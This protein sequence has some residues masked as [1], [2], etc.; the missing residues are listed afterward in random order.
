LPYLERA[1]FS[2][3]AECTSLIKQ[4]KD[5]LTHHRSIFSP[6]NLRKLDFFYINT[7]KCALRWNK[8]E[9]IYYWSTSIIN[10]IHKTETRENSSITRL[11]YQTVISQ[12]NKWANTVPGY[13]G[14]GIRCLGGV[15]IPCRPVTSAVSPISIGG[16]SIPC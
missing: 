8:F 2:W 9:C 10:V 11:T 4:V 7:F 5:L 14:G 6:G 15:S 13:T 16:V 12:R 3:N 1:S